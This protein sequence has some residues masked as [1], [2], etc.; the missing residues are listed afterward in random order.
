MIYQLRKYLGRF[1]VLINF[2]L[3]G[4]VAALPVVTA[5]V[6]AG[7]VVGIIAV[8]NLAR[9]Q[10][11]DI[12]F[13]QPA[14]V[15]VMYKK[16]YSNVWDATIDAL[17][18]MQES[19][20]VMDK[21]A[22]FIRTRKKNLNDVSWIGKGLGKATFRYE[23]NFT[24]RKKRGLI[25]VALAVPF[26]EEKVFIASKEKNIPEGSNMMRHIFYR[27]LNK[28]LNPYSVKL[29][30]SPTQDIRH[31]PMSQKTQPV[32]TIKKR[33]VTSDPQ[34]VDNKKIEGRKPGTS[35]PKKETEKPLLW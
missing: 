13:D 15:E 12:D 2:S 30:D 24:I 9:E 21:N 8:V 25:S 31:A 28:R 20:S 17:M 22:G 34:E 23:L 6:V 16:N 7:T 27:N 10:Y 14:P 18:E 19:T 32:K 4:C 33:R 26:W 1:S 11:P 3:T 5:L 29:P 35:K